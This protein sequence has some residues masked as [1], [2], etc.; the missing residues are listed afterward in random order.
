MGP[1]ALDTESKQHVIVGSRLS[2][3]GEVMYAMLWLPQ[4]GN[5]VICCASCRRSAASNSFEPCRRARRVGRPQNISRPKFTNLNTA[6]RGA[7]WVS[8]RTVISSLKVR[9][10]TGG[11]H[12]NCTNIAS[13]WDGGGSVCGSA[14][15]QLTAS[16]GRLLH[17]T[18]AP[19][20][21]RNTVSG[22]RRTR[23]PRGLR[24]RVTGCPVWGRPPWAKSWSVPVFRVGP[25]ALAFRGPGRA[26][27][28]EVGNREQT[29]PSNLGPFHRCSIAWLV[30]LDG[31]RQ[32]RVQGREEEQRKRGEH[33]ETKRRR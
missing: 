4:L 30:K 1:G 19:T 8:E 18:V 29:V 27:R 23:R 20:M 3:G 26:R 21:A 22:S 33:G 15:Q 32:C 5:R 12:C 31:G 28:L 7:I 17:H 6:R 10:P 11:A 16:G 14:T 2:H 24:L 9:K 13:L 25:L